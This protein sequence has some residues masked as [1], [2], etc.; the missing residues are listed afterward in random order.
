LPLRLCPTPEAQAGDLL[1]KERVP[2]LA[3]APLLVAA[4]ERLQAERPPLRLRENV[5]SHRGALLRS[6]G[7]CWAGH[8]AEQWP[9]RYE[10]LT[11]ECGSLQSGASG[12]LAGSF[13]PAGPLA[14]ADQVLLTCEQDARPPVPLIGEHVKLARLAGT[15]WMPSRVG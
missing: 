4:A 12:A 6:G 5:R 11:Y 3:P 13:L 7:L 1:V 9:G 2:A 15:A 8:R 14:P 10:L